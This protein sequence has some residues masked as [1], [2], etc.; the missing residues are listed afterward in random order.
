MKGEMPKRVSPF[1]LWWGADEVV[2][3]HRRS[4]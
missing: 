3:A 2:A 1:G 4:S